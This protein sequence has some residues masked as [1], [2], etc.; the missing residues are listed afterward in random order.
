MHQARR[1]RGYSALL[2]ALALIATA[3]G[4][5]LPDNAFVNASGGNGTAAGNRSSQ[6]TAKGATANAQ[7]PGAAGATGAGAT[8]APGATPGAGAAGADPA[9]QGGGADGPNQASDSGVT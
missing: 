8:P 9:A 3:C 4:T 6:A 7:A 1:R 2:A 5:R